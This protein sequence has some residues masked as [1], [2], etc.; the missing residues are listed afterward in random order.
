VIQA[1]ESLLLFQGVLGDEVGQALCAYAAE[2][3]TPAYVHLARAL[4]AA[5]TSLRAHLIDRVLRDEN[6]FTG[7]AAAGRV[8][9]DLLAVAR[10]DLQVLGA[11]AALEPEVPAGLPGLPGAE[12]GGTQPGGTQPG[13]TQSGEARSGGTQSQG[14][15]A[16]RLNESRDWGD[17]TDSLAEHIRRHGAGDEGRYQAF[18]WEEGRMAGIADPD[19]V[20]LEDLVGNEDAKATVTRNTEQFLAGYPANN[21]LLYGD[22]GTGKSS[23]VKALLHRYGPE[24]LRIVE[25]SRADLGQ[26]GAVMRTLRSR[27]LR[28]IL[29]IDDLSFEDFE[30][31]FKTFKAMLEGSLERRPANVLVYATTNRRRL[32]RERWSDRNQADDEVRPG[33]TLQEVNSLA[34]RFGMTVM[35]ATPD[36]EQYLAIVES[37]ARS[38]GVATPTDELRRAALQWAMWHNGWSGRTARQFMDDQAGRLGIR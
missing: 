18:R 16:A 3:G 5:G 33:D 36:Q 11:L 9:P 29:F 12:P 34:D 13:G 38:R 37:M 32:V 20:R 17:L 7:A 26:L 21:L 31:A 14:G 1:E 24:G 19:P 25:V 22:R 35:F 4:W 10:H 2:P 23:T 15:F 30:V 27:H 8:A 28:Y 6:A